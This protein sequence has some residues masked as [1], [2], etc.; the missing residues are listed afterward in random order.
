MTDD[1]DPALHSLHDAVKH[2]RELATKAAATTD[3][4]LKNAMKTEASRHKDAR[5]AGF[6]LIER[7]TK[8]I[9]NAV[10]VAQSEI[11]TIQAKVRAPLVAKDIINET[12][13]RELR[14]RF[15]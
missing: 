10:R 8:S 6:E 15:R 12:H 13:Q 4:V 1:D 5:G 14:E 9:D 2:T 7:A 3:I 11:S